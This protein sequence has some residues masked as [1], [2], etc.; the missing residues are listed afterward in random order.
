MLFDVCIWSY[1]CLSFSYDLSSGFLVSLLLDCFCSL[2]VMCLVPFSV[3][4]LFCISSDVVC[5]DVSFFGMSLYFVPP[6]CCL[7]PLMS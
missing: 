1:V 7:N 5:F 2:C 3:S 6:L 4:H